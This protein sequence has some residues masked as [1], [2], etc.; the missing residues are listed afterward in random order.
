MLGPVAVWADDGRP[1][2]VPEP[3]VRA[4]LADLLVAPGRVVPADRLIDDLWGD[5]PPRNPAGTLQARVSQLRGIL[6]GRDAVA[7]RPPGYALRAGEVDAE[8][9]EAL[10]VRAGDSTDPRVK[11]GLLADAL[12]LWR[13]PAFADFRD[14]EFARAAIAGLEERR[15]AAVEELAETRLRLGE[16]AR[17]AAELAESVERH[18]ARERLR[19][20]YMHALYLSGRQGEALAAY[21]DLRA[22]LAED[23]GV[24]PGPA[25]KELHQAILT[26]DPALAVAETTA[27]GPARGNLPEP[28]SELI[29]REEA[30][31]EARALLGSHRLVTLTGPGGVGKTRLALE[32]AARHGGA[33]PDGAWLVELAPG[34]TTGVA[35]LADTVLGILGVPDEPGVTAPLDRLAAVLRARRALLVLDN[36]EHVIGTAAELAARLLA[37][38]PGLRI[39]ATSREPLGIE[40]ERLQVVP[41][42]DVPAG[43]APEELA[44]SSAVRLFVAR[45]A[46]A[47][48]GFALDGGTAGPVA[49]ICRRL[50]GIPLALELAATRIRAL[51]AAELAARLD[52]RFR[53]LAAGRR[54][55]PARQR[56]LRAVIDWSWEP[57]A[58]PERTVLRRLAVHA[59]G[60]TLEAA[61]RVCGD[62]GLDV[63]EVLASL[64]DRSLVAVSH[65]GEPRYRLLESVAAYGLERLREAGEES[66][67]RER[68]ARHYTAF[69]ERAAGLLRGPGQGPALERLDR[70]GPNFCA[71]LEWSASNG[72]ADL[73]LRQANAQSWYWYLRGRYGEAER[74]LYMALAAGGGDAARRAEAIA[75][76]N[77][78]LMVAGTGEDTERLRLEAL[79]AYDALGGGQ[80]PLARARAEWFLV[81]VH[82]PYGD[83]AANGARPP[84]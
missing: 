70:E 27:A 36:C 37:A 46:A 83:L 5:R 9:F 2:D 30:A 55:A 29:G 35:V 54:D 72:F 47:A 60:C 38:A 1:V 42:L 53:L 18:P 10:V 40:G 71:A 3:K 32:V 67:I 15:L 78:M 49:T 24:D 64:V 23:L 44:R 48:P 19:G 33:Y 58:E 57:L 51:G 61:E 26:Q 14:A 65:D 69:A 34:A 74:S 82:W 17:V 6:G 13:G 62:P 25:L 59:D 22:T 68:H 31:A 81:Y 41:P 56:T 21:E 80:D 63:V 4:L 50:D 12:A 75:W 7:H 79:A 11:A 76:R 77:G 16:H 84:R 45:A 39:L 43:T 66:A 73:A 28:V 8:R 52:D 20:A